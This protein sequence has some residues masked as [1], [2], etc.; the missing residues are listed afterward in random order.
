MAALKGK[1]KKNEIPS[2]SVGRHG[3]GNGLFLLVKPSGS[4][5]WIIR[6]TIKGQKN[7]NGAP[8]R[9][10]FGIGGTTVVTLNEAREKALE[11]RRMAVRGLNPR[12]NATRDI[13]T[14]IEIAKQ[15]H[16]DRK[17]TWKSKKH[18]ENWLR[19]VE[20]YAFPKIGSM[21]VSDIGQPEVLSV[22]SPIWTSK[23]ETARRV[24][25][26]IKTILD[27]AKSK[28]FR[29]GENP[30]SE[31]Q[32]AHVL[33]KVKIKHKHHPA[34]R[35]Q[36]TPAFFADLRSREAMAAKALMFTCLTASR[37]NEVIKAKWNEF[38]FDE[39]I[40]IVPAE[41]M[42]MDEDH[43]IPL[44]KEMLSIVEPL[45]AMASEYVF[46]GQKRHNPLSS[47]AM[48]MLLRRM[49]VEDV[50]VHGFR[51]TF[52]D[53]VSETTNTPREL[54]EISLSHQVG[55]EV[56]QAYARSDLLDRRRLLMERW[57]A[58]VAGDVAKIVRIS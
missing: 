39:H 26:R 32:N 48:L 35:W 11:F 18:G 4:R 15:V 45:K 14:F 2:L 29:I 22:L 47:H 41:R 19:S 24:S 36:D 13:P 28:G 50:T 54:A 12:H 51:S 37:T 9:T 58:Y 52:R 40:W 56:E 42:K 5:S 46:E 3:D 33:P 43:R 16:I 17:P 10:D 21:Q 23:H 20:L 31:I 44:T 27:V 1:L 57:S 8:L 55:N 30:V 7:R 53:W 25:Q 34:M 49:K 6:L 38:D